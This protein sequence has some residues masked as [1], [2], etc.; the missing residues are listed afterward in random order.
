MPNFNVEKVKSFAVMGICCILVVLNYTS[1]PG[2]YEVVKRLTLYFSGRE[3]ANSTSLPITSSDHYF[4]QNIILI[5]TIYL[6]IICA[7]ISNFGT[8]F[9]Y[10]QRGL[11]VYF[12]LALIPTLI[13]ISVVLFLVLGP[14][15]V[16][17]YLGQFLHHAISK[18]T[19]NTTK[20]F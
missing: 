20:S 19:I 12:S 18:L 1:T 11:A 13:R 16:D 5:I 10:K 15:F 17:Q 9:Y 6:L 14:I 4:H 7:F 3:D 8:M 2:F